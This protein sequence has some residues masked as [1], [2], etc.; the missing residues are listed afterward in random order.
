LG[1]KTAEIVGYF[2]LLVGFWVFHCVDVGNA[3]WR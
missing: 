3:Y 1:I 2:I